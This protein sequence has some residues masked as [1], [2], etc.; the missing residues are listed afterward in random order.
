MYNLQSTLIE[1]YQLYKT[2]LSVLVGDR[3]KHG[4]DW[5]YL[6]EDGGAGNLGTVVSVCGIG[7]CGIGYKYDVTVEWD[8]IGVQELYRCGSQGKYDLKLV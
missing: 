4:P 8:I 5:N 7:V 1:R 6:N 3:V 2:G